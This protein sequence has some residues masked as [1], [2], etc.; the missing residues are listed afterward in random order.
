MD[1]LTQYLAAI[2]AAITA[3]AGAIIS[4]VSFVKSIK[5][6]RRTISELAASKKDIKI[7]REGIVQAFKDSV[8]TKDLK[9]SVNKEVRKILGEELE[10]MRETVAKSEERRT[11]MVYWCLQILDWTAAANKMTPEQHAEIKELLA[12]IAEEEQIVDTND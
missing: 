7:T 10:K 6:E 9:V 1:F 12:E 3:A 11:K 8:V 5:S 2:S 4:I